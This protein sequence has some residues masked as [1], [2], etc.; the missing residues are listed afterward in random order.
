MPSTYAASIM[1]DR[2]RSIISFRRTNFP[3]DITLLLASPSSPLLFFRFFFFLLLLLLLLSLC[4]R[5]ETRMEGKKKKERGRKRTLQNSS[6]RRTSPKRNS[7]IFHNDIARQEFNSPVIIII[8]ITAMET[9]NFSPD[10]L[11]DICSPDSSIS[12]SSTRE[13][14]CV[15][16]RVFVSSRPSASTN[17][18][19]FSPR[20]FIGRI[21]GGIGR[22][23]RDSFCADISMRGT[24]S[25]F[26]R[27]LVTPDFDSVRSFV[28]RRSV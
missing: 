26:G 13:K 8:I 9:G 3:S 6:S 18:T 25:G 19:F 24:R 2:R 20:M 5:A 21:D 1:R 12:S 28:P 17:G 23:E 16:S 15:A 10:T 14:T 22:R 4:R 27:G 11:A 7:A